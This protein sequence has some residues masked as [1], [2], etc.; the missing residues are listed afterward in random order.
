M[1]EAASAIDVWDGPAELRNP[2]Y[3]YLLMLGDDSL[4]LGHRLSEWCGHGPFLEEDIA[5]ANIALDLIGRADALLQLAGRVEGKGRTQDD[6][7]F[8]RDVVEFRNAALVELPR[9]DFAFTMIRQFLYDAYAHPLYTA[10][11]EGA[12]ASLAGI[13][14]KAAK[15]TVYHLR[16]SSEWVRR[17]GGGTDES[18]RRAWVAL[19]NAWMYTEELFDVGGE[20]DELETA[21]WIPPS[22]TIRDAWSSTVTDVLSDAGLQPPATEFFHSG[23]RSGLHTEHIGH[24]LSE[25][26][27]VARS[28]PGAQW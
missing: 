1:T 6:L 9:G 16:H 20:S 14:A 17:L 13:A 5:L 25:M 2:F 15:E 27:I 18:R 21:G 22:S 23:A 24:L 3:G 4:I 10:L 7:A 12:P 11:A 19:E 28:H 8:F 26:Q